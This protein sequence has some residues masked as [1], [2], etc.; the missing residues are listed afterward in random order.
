MIHVT[1]ARWRMGLSCWAVALIFVLTPVLTGTA[2]VSAQEVLTNETVVGMVKA[3]LPES[4]IVQKIRSSSR[5]FDTSTNALIRLKQAGVPDK[6]IEAMVTEPGAAT[7]ATAAKTS[8]G[9]PMIAHVKAGG[10]KTLDPIHGSK[11]IS[12]APFAGS[13]QEVVLPSAR[14]EYRITEREPVFTTPQPAQQWI[15]AKL[16]PGKRDR[17]LP[18]SKNDGWGWGGATFRD[19]LDPKYAVK[20][21]A[22]SGPDGLTKL[23]PEEPLAPGEY[24]FIAVT[25]GQPNMVEVFDFGID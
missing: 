10:A 24:G 25:R 18:M 15:L 8:S 22:E 4:V 2:P 9:D 16:K 12:A 20:M 13:R 14:A 7:A 17:N 5:K 1:Q 3:G 21:I 6:V 19:G 23:R 11:E